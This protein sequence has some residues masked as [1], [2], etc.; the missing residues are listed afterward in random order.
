VPDVEHGIHGLA[1][2]NE[3][4]IWL[5]NLMT[6][7]AQ[8]EVDP[9]PSFNCRLPLFTDDMKS[10]TDTNNKINSLEFGRELAFFSE[11]HATT[12]DGPVLHSKPTKAYVVDIGDTELLMFTNGVPERPVA[13]ARQRAGKREVYW[14]ESYDELPFDEAL[15]AKPA[16]VKVEEAK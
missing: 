7:T 9:G 1:V 6:K 11:N 10:A 2:I 5:I 14:Y 15:F 3:P 8:H 13:V 16:G 12:K 4:D